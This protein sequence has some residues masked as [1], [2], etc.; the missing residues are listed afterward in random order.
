MRIRTHV[1]FWNAPHTPIIDDND[2]DGKKYELENQRK[3]CMEY[4]SFS[5]VRSHTRIKFVPL[6]VCTAH[7][8]V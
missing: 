6:N 4:G 8:T 1:P 7:I 3:D 5:L 2:D